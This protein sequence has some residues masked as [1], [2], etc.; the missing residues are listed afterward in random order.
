MTALV[1]A[2]ISAKMGGYIMSHD[3]GRL[4][5]RICG[6]S[7]YFPVAEV[8]MQNGERLIE[9]TCSRGHTDSYWD[10]ETEKLAETV[11]HTELSRAAIIGF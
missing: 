9:L 2:P 10:I 8:A 5:C 11:P 1:G 7:I 6:R 3:L 4:E